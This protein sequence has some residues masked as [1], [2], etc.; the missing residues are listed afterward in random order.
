MDRQENG[1]IDQGIMLD[2]SLVDWPI[3]LRHCQGCGDMWSV[4]EDG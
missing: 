2:L 3:G 1:Q 4:D